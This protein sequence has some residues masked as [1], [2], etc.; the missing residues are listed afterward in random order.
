MVM[1]VGMVTGM[2]KLC[3][4]LEAERP[5]IQ[6]SN[7]D[8]YIGYNNGLVMAQAIVLKRDI[9]EVVRCKDCKWYCGIGCV[10]PHHI[11]PMKNDDFCSYG[12]RRE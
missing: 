11:R 12:E 2:N 5:V 10:K 4:L 1:T 9:V 6:D 7:D 3:E 8:Y